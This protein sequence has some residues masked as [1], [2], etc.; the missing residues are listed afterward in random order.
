MIVDFIFW[1]KRENGPWKVQHNRL[2]YEKD[3]LIP[4]DEMTVP[5]FG[6]ELEKYPRG[7]RHIA[8]AQYGIGLPI[9]G[10][11]PTKKRDGFV[12]MYEAIHEWLEGNEVDL[13]WDRD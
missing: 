5:V 13:L 10:H 3:K 2:F 9:L 11:L 7:Y 1:C 6:K 8:V 12:M 4:V